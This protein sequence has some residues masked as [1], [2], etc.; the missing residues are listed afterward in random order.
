MLTPKWRRGKPRVATVTHMGTDEAPGQAGTPFPLVTGDRLSPR[1]IANA[2]ANIKESP[3]KTTTRVRS[4]TQLIHLRP[5]LADLFCFCVC[6]RSRA[7]AVEGF[8]LRVIA[9]R[10]W[11]LRM[12][13]ALR[14]LSPYSYLEPSAFSRAVPLRRFALVHLRCKGPLGDLRGDV[15]GGLMPFLGPAEVGRSPARILRRRF[16]SLAAVVCVCGVLVCPPK[17]ESQSIKII[18]R[19]VARRG[20]RQTIVELK[21][22]GTRP[23]LHVCSG[24]NTFERVH[25]RELTSDLPWLTVRLCCDPSVMME[26]ILNCASDMD[27]G[28]TLL[29]AP[30]TRTGCSKVS[31]N[32]V[33]GELI[34]TH[35]L[36]ALTHSIDQGLTVT[37]S[38]LSARFIRRFPKSRLRA[39]NCTSLPLQATKA[40]MLSLTNTTDR[41]RP[42]FTPH[43]RHGQH[44][45]R[46]N[47]PPVP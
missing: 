9:G 46:T 23:H 45:R 3:G 24:R 35:T 38:A 33:G 22:S 27:R 8:G 44:Q 1:P 41:T 25:S 47:L 26:R 18:C 36:N 43:V 39:P 12:E 5:S 17:Q 14:M 37:G 19:S 2:N 40:N 42:S 29:S 32:S 13:S 34:Q 31:V 28:G 6:I 7:V 15:A 30:E 21:R 4:R 16:Q 11:L 10:T 20:T